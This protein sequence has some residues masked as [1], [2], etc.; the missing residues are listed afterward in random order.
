MADQPFKLIKTEGFRKNDPESYILS[1]NL[2]KAV[3]VALVLNQPLI[4]TGEPGTGKTQLAYKLAHDLHKQ[5]NGDFLKEPLE[6]HTK[7]TSTA[8]DLFYEYD[9]ISHFHQS[10]IAKKDL[11][12][13]ILKKVID[14]KNT[15]LEPDTSLTPNS[16][17]VSEVNAASHITLQALGKA[18]ALS[19]EDYLNSD[20]SL[21]ANSKK[22]RSSVVLIDE[23]DKAPRD[24]PND[25]LNEIDQFTFRIKELKQDIN[26]SE[27]KKILVIMTSNSEKSLPLPFLRRCVFY[28]I[29]FPDADELLEITLGKSKKFEEIPEESLIEAIDHFINHVRMRVKKK[30]PATSE[31]ISWLHV[32]E[33][34]NFLMKMLILITY[35][36]SRKTFLSSVILF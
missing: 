9:A 34:E 12:I 33:L 31:L 6:F 2:R 8:Q 24:F 30:L 3:N 14:S 20:N 22:S 10:N 26:K 19:N 15:N 1:E 21:I 29:P 25:I 7:T 28:H 13:S 27:D 16:K 17:K 36:I 18:I 35:Q 32:L 11:E 23:I 5:T 4:L